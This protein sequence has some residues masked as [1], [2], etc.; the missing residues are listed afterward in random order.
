MKA[1]DYFEKYAEALISDDHDVS[2]KASVKLV[3]DMILEI[4][5]VMGK[6][7]ARFDNA[8]IS[9]IKEQNEKWLALVRMFEKKYGASPLRREGFVDLLERMM[10]EMKV[11]EGIK[12]RKQPINLNT[13]TRE[14]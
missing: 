11:S 14:G 1:K 5:E 7:Q 3:N 6:R 9:V 12:P 2:V 8:L 13:P 4:N 10:P